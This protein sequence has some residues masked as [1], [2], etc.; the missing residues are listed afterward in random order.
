MIAAMGGFAIEDA[1]L[2]SAAQGVPFATVMTAF[3]AGGTLVFATLA[4]AKGQSLVPKAARSRA[5]AVRAVFEVI[6]R[7]FYTLAIVL[8]PL[9][10][11]SAILQ[12]TPIVVV[13]GAALF[14]GERVG[15]RRWSAI[16]V[17]FLGV[18]VILKPG[19]DAFVALSL[20]AVAGMLGFAG[21]DLAT[22]AA[23]P[24]IGTFTLGVYGFLPILL[25]GIGWG[26]VTGEMAAR[27]GPA[28]AGTLITAVL[29][30][31]VGYASLTIAMR[32]GEISA[33]APFRYSRL[34]F[35][36]AFGILLFGETLETNM[37]V[38]SAIIVAAGLYIMMRG[39]RAA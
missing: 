36:V 1:L 11:T 26:L 4:Q 33:V 34:L 37:I 10:S 39:R 18:L 16:A 30:G 6:G 21:R 24:G 31:V 17:G 2:K 27:I 29:F 19:S 22:R 23:P 14:F 25:V 20:L 3:G 8:T 7:M 28:E 38:G 32:T 9:S 15:W 13:A 12:A 35:G 5:I